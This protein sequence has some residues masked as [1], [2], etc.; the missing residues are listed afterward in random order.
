MT[1]V[2]TVQ[3]VTHCVCDECI[4]H[5]LRKGFKC[6]NSKTVYLSLP[7]NRGYCAEN[8]KSNAKHNALFSRFSL[9]QALRVTMMTLMGMI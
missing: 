2:G 1:D 5:D 6:F 7:S 9:I 3:V 8:D 4:R